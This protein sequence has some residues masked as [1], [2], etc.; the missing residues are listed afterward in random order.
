MAHM[1]IYAT[2]EYLTLGAG[3]GLILGKAFSGSIQ[4]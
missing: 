1:N 2:V 4:A 3:G